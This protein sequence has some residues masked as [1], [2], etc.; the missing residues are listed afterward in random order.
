MASPFLNYAFPLEAFETFEAQKQDHIKI[1]YFWKLFKFKL[2][3]EKTQSTALAKMHNAAAALESAKSCPARLD[4]L[5][6]IKK[7][8]V[9]PVRFF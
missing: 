1:E 5:I 7:R 4:S 8:Y 9:Y 6:M 2:Y 3:L